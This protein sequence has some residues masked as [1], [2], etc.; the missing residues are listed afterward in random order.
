[1]GLKAI[2]TVATTA[3]KSKAPEIL[4]GLGLVSFVGTVIVAS[5]ETIKATEI[6]AEHEEAKR[7]ID[8]CHATK[9]EDVYPEEIY[10]KDVITCYSKTGIALAKNYAPAAGLFVLSVACI[11][12]SYGILK[13]RNV[14]LVAAYNAV[15]EAFEKYR[16]RV[17]E[18]KGEDA[19][20]YYMTGQKMKKVT[21]KD[22]N[23]N[24]VER[25]VLAGE[26]KDPS[27]MYMF[28]FSKYKENGERNLQWNPNSRYYNQMFL[29]GQNDMLDDRLYARTLF[30]RHHNVDVPGYVFLNEIRDAL[31]EDYNTAG[32]IVGN[33]Y[34][35][36]DNGTNG[37]NGHI[38]FHTIEG[39]EI[40][41]ETGEK[42]DCYYINPNVDGPIFEKID[43]WK[44]YRKYGKLTTVEDAVEFEPVS[45]PQ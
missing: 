43:D 25:K 33:L 3:A 21:E 39:E 12:G 1:M 42:I 23:G 40:D 44:K 11:L 31:G 38:N 22:E 9:G 28:K 32:Q 16:R 34:S 41:P 6:L 36:E 14:A 20:V 17:I 35:K 24:K 2:M 29:R 4:L 13:K 7:D 45:D 18:D 19:D 30:D 37:C 8:E 10:K 15:S 5:K 27:T 26:P